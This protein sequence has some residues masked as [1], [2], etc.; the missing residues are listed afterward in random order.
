[1]NS[2]ELRASTCLDT[3]NW[4]DRFGGCDDYV[5]FGGCSKADDYEG[6]MGPATDHCCNCG[7]GSH[8]YPPTN[9]PTITNSPAKSATPSSS[10]TA[11]SSPTMLANPTQLCVDTRNWEDNCGDGC[12][13]YEDRH[14]DACS[15]ADEKAGDMGPATKHCCYCGKEVSLK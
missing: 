4:K 12:D 1:M 13:W 6:D 7:G 14:D 3:P 15:Y 10:P 5:S 9:S 8:T 2:D 11:S